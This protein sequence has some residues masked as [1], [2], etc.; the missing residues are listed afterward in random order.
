MIESVTKTL[1]ALRN[2]AILFGDQDI[3]RAEKDGISYNYVALTE[4]QL[5][6]IEHG[7]NEQVALQ[8]QILSTFETNQNA[9]FLIRIADGLDPVRGS[10]FD[11]LEGNELTNAF[12][13]ES[14]F[15]RSGSFGHKPLLERE[16]QCTISGDCKVGGNA[17]MVS[18]EYTTG[19]YT[20]G[21]YAG[22]EKTLMESAVS[23]VKDTFNAAYNK[24]T[25]A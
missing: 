20:T 17:K 14:L 3:G 10:R 6:T 8:D 21:T 13:R 5:Q 11:Y 23:G 2:S 15:S 1:S 7:L 12:L 19:T 22:G 24:L 16:G 4:E 18:G 25:G 9:V